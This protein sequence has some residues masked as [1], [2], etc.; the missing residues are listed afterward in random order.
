MINLARFWAEVE[1]VFLKLSHLS[2]PPMTSDWPD[3]M[4]F[5]GLF[6]ACALHFIVWTV[7]FS[8]KEKKVLLYIIMAFCATDLIADILYSLDF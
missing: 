2:V 5:C 1:R 6:G 4:H 7:M 3:N 8:V